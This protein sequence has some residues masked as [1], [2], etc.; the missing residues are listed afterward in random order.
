MERAVNLSQLMVLKKF[1]S[2]FSALDGHYIFAHLTGPDC[3]QQQLHNP[4]RVDGMT[5]FLCHEGSMTID[6]NLTGYDLIPNTLL[7]TGPESIIAVKDVDVEALD[8]YMLFLSTDFMR[9]L[10]IDPN[11]FRRLQITDQYEHR[12]VLKIESREASLMTRYFDLLHHNTTSNTDES[13]IKAISKC[14]IS[15]L[16]YQ[17]LQ[18]ATRRIDLL[19]ASRP[20][21]GKASQYNRKHRHAY[22]RDFMALLHEH[23]LTQRSV[24]FYAEQMFVTPK[25]LSLVVKEITGKTAAQWIDELVILEA[26]NMLRFSEK[27]VQQVAYA[28]NFPNQSSFGKYFKNLTGMSPSAYQKS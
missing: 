24:A 2:D 19:E 16:L 15:A 5:W 3:L 17:V 8:A 21:S 6:L 20:A 22:V 1:V 7:I 26:K 27:N 9:D 25:Y 28:L 14:L 18:F 10:N 4:F 23:H 13:I 11:A 12:P